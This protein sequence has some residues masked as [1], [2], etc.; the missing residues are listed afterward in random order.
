MAMR[1]ASIWR[2]VNQAGSMAWMPKSPK[3]TSL[4]P[5]ALP[6]IRPRCCLRCLTFL[7]I[8]MSVH[9][10]AEVRGLVVLAGPTLDLLVLGE[11]ALELIGHGRWGGDVGGRQVDQ[12]LG[13]LGLA[14]GVR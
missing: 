9:L 1:A 12:A 3:V 11:D 2:A 5:L 14:G 6:L 10:L 4:P 8:N 7:G 13:D